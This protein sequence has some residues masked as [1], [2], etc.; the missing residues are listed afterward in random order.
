MFKRIDGKSVYADVRVTSCACGDNL[1]KLLCDSDDFE[2]SHSTRDSLTVTY[3]SEEQNVRLVARFVRP[4]SVFAKLHKPKKR[5]ESID[6]TSGGL[7]VSSDNDG[8]LLVWQT[9]DGQLRV[10]TSCSVMLTAYL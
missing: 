8:N 4:E 9:A 6:V 3:S 7:G 1:S 2:A 10:S 5:I